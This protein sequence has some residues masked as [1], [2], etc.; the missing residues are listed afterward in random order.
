MKKLLVIATL[1]LSLLGF[2]G[3]GSDNTGGDFS[4]NKK[5]Y[6]DGF[7]SIDSFEN[8]MY[9]ALENFADTEGFKDLSAKIFIL[10]EIGKSITS[11]FS[12]KEGQNYFLTV[13]GNNK[14]EIP[15]VYDGQESLEFALKKQFKGASIVKSAEKAIIYLNGEIKNSFNKLDL[16]ESTL[17]TGALFSFTEDFLYIEN[18]DGDE[19]EYYEELVVGNVYTFT[20]KSF[21]RGYNNE[22]SVLIAEEEFVMEKD[23]NFLNMVMGL[24]T[25]KISAPVSLEINEQVIG[26]FMGDEQ[27]EFNQKENYVDFKMYLG[28]EVRIVTESDEHNFKLTPAKL[29]SH[30]NGKS[31]SLIETAPIPY[32]V[33][34]TNG[35]K[36]SMKQDFSTTFNQDLYAEN[37]SQEIVVQIIIDDFVS[38]DFNNFGKSEVSLAFYDKQDNRI[39]FSEE[40][41]YTEGYF[42][43][44]Y[45]NE[46]GLDFDL[47]YHNLF[48]DLEECPK[49]GCEKETDEVKK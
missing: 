36:A 37:G 45:T 4:S 23:L 20:L 40:E 32:T 5:E 42:I 9:V 28:K 11:N 18:E 41:F 26:I 19:I 15:F 35:Y 8:K 22:N 43:L 10:D 25:E 16:T 21:I 31:Y 7:V 46:P 2:T 12:L 1:M 49:S 30:L 38:V 39:D 48:S 14:I 6:R 13:T 17:L 47:K 3:C 33:I 27:I 44:K 29:F 34:T 24:Y